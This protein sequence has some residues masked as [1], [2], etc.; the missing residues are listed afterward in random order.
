MD[1]FEQAWERV[2]ISRDGENVSTE[3]RPLLR[4]VYD[5]LKCQPPNLHSVKNSLGNLLSFLSSSH[6]RTTA[7]CYAIDLFFSLP[8]WDGNVDWESLPEPLTDIIGYMGGA[9]H[10]TVFH[11]EIANNFLGLPEQ[12]LELLEKWN[13]E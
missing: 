8:D 12:L 3:L 7:N 1:I 13:P 6:G 2:A 4:K 11:P 10:D 9:L 5:E